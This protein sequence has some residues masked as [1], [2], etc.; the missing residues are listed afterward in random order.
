MARRIAF[1]MAGAVGTIMAAAALAV[2]AGA[3]RAEPARAAAAP[4]YSAP[5]PA[6]VADSYGN[7][8]VF[9][10]NT[11]DELTEAYWDVKMA[12]WYGPVTV[13]GL[14]RLG[15]EPAAAVLSTDPY[16][17]PGGGDLEGICLYWMGSGAAHSLFFS[18]GGGS[19]WQKP[20]DLH[21]GPLASG[22]AA[23]GDVYVPTVAPVQ[24]V[25]VYW[26]GTD[27]NIWSTTGRD[28][29]NR[30]G[31]TPAAPA[32]Y[33]GL[34]LGPLGSGPAASTDNA[35]ETDAVYW[36]GGDSGLWSSGYDVKTH[37]WVS[38]TARQAWAGHLG[39]AP[40]VVLEQ[41]EIPGTPL[42]AWQGVY[43]N[44][45]WWNSGGGQKASQIPGM[46]PLGSVPSIAWSPAHP[47]DYYIFWKGRNDYLYEAYY[48][49]ATG[50]WSRIAFPQM[51][52]LG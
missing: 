9:W 50:S 4:S 6:A 34:G 37:S 18:C 27:G 42:I 21:M 49:F 45:L 43:P 2:G 28:P 30:T 20:H 33:N 25:D 14:G 31:Y 39:S 52:L 32:S 16:V 19:T 13:P 8:Y 40:S 22:P 48:N 36:Q 51:S 17:G 46:G 7:E 23:V 38:G 3:A 26:K 15:S 44:G 12:R 47:G 1:G 24:V 41:L 11:Q 29:F 10:R 5:G 35:Q